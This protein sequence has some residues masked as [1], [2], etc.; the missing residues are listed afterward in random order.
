MMT[1]PVIDDLFIH[2]FREWLSVEYS[3]SFMQ[4]FSVKSW[5]VFVRLAGLLF[6]LS[7]LI[8]NILICVGRNK[9]SV[10]GQLTL[11]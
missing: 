3:I 4:L 10:W 11:Q 2:V 1:S 7:G 6:S 9:V 8:S 5:L